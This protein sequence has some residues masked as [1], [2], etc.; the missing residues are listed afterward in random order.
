M[1][2]LGELYEEEIT[3]ASKAVRDKHCVGREDVSWAAARLR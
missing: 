1:T 2:R 3:H